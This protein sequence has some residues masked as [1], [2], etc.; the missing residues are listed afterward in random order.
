MWVVV[1][2]ARGEEVGLAREVFGEDADIMA[3]DL[4]LGDAVD[5]DIGVFAHREPVFG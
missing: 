2:H 1:G 4:F 3:L 5:E